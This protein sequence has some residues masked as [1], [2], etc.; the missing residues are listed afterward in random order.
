MLMFYHKG[1]I[2]LTYNLYIDEKWGG[3]MSDLQFVIP[4][5]INLKKSSQY[6]EKWVQVKIDQNPEILGLGTLEVWQKEKIQ[7]GKG[8]LDLLLQDES[9]NTR[10]EVEIQLGQT[11]ETHIIRVIEYWDIEKKR[12][13]SFD[14]I[15]VLVAE[16][17]TSRFLNVLSLFNGTIPLIVLKIE[18][19]KVKD[20]VSLIFTKVLDQSIIRESSEQPEPTDREY[21]EKKRASK[22]T[23][24]MVDSLFEIINGIDS[25]LELKYNKFYIGISRDDQPFLFVDFK[26]QKTWLRLEIRLAESEETTE[27]IKKAKFELLDYSSRHGQY[28]IRLSKEDIVSSKELLSDLFLQAYLES[29]GEIPL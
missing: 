22:K 9:G 27:K 18:A 12:N 23:V 21:W 1:F 8:R 17:V 29:G 5:R 28:I 10:Y 15:A 7:S 20:Y 2:N 25:R 26:P 14:H 13:P 24:E 11:D 4:E 3:V 19:I 6:T 16:D